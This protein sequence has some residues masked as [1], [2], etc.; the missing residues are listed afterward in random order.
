MLKLMGMHRVFHSYACSSQPCENSFSDIRKMSHQ[1]NGPM[2]LFNAAKRLGAL[3]FKESENTLH[4][5]AISGK[6]R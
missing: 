2:A 5:T 1:D 3:H 4:L 6:D